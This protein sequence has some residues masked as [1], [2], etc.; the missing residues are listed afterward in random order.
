MLWYQI[1]TLVLFI[2]SVTMGVVILL[3]G[4][5][6]FS[7]R[8]LNRA[9]YGAATEPDFIVECENLQYS[10][11]TVDSKDQEITSWADSGDPVLFTMVPDSG[12]YPPITGAKLPGGNY[13]PMRAFKDATYNKRMMKVTSSLPA[14]S[15]NSNS[16]TV[17]ALVKSS[18]NLPFSFYVEDGKFWSDGNSGFQLRPSS[19]Y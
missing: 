3:M 7:K 8:T 11:G 2:L 15:Y 17:H 10:G 13:Y 14:F 4:S 16:I 18:V 6:W 12:T 9:T 19:L 5:Q 1:L